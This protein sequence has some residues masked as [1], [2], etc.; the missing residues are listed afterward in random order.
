[1]CLN[2]FTVMVAVT[3]V[4]IFVRLN[5][6]LYSTFNHWF[7]KKLEIFENKLVKYSQYLNLY[8]K[9]IKSISNLKL[10]QS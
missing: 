1:M 2:N 3:S 9:P 4:N 5:M 7:E 8:A 10:V 6:N